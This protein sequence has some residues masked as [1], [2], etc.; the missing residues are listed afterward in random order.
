[1]LLNINF[2]PKLMGQVA[3]DP[4]LMFVSG[5]ITFVVGLAIV[6]VHN[7]W[8]GGWPVVVTVLG[9]LALLG[10]LARMLFPI[11]LTAMVAGSAHNTGFLI[12]ESVVF[13]ALGGFL[14]FKGYS[15]HG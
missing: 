15:Q 2:L 5:V 8:K 11:Q 3:N 9:W 12:G 10:G 1:M 14:S 6:R 7:F 4:A 13:L